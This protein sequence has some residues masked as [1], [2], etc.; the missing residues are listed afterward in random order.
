[1]KLKTILP[2]ESVC[3]DCDACV[4]ICPTPHLP[5]GCISGSRNFSSS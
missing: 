2:G 1:M 3:E 5:I 4:M